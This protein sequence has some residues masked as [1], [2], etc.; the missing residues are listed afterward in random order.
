VHAEAATTGWHVDPVTVAWAQQR[1]AA[2][3]GGGAPPHRLHALTATAEP[4]QLDTALDLVMRSS[5]ARMSAQAAEQAQ[6]LAQRADLTPEQLLADTRDTYAAVQIAAVR[7]TGPAGT[8]HQ[9]AVHAHRS[10]TARVDSAPTTANL[11]ALRDRTAGLLDLLDPPADNAHPN[12]GSTLSAR[13]DLDH[14]AEATL[15]EEVTPDAGPEL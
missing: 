2:E 14:T 6:Q 8:A 5:L 10:T 15:D 7:M 12:P 1:H 4:A 3:H 11:T 9:L 13:L